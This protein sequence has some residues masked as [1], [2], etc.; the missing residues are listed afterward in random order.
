MTHNSAQL[1]MLFDEYRTF[2]FEAQ[3]TDGDV[4]TDQ[5][6]RL[7]IKDGAWTPTGARTLVEL[8]H[9]YG[10]FFLRNAAALAL[11]L[12]IEDGKRSF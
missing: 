5:L 3:A 2:V 6:I 11:A 12:N 9:E 1:D 4:D 7:L 10:S 8:V